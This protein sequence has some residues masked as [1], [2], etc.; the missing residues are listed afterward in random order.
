MRFAAKQ[1][2]CISRVNLKIKNSRNNYMRKANEDVLCLQCH[3]SDGQQWANTWA[4][5][6]DSSVE[7]ERHVI[8]VS[9]I[10]WVGLTIRIGVLNLPSSFFRDSSKVFANYCLVLAPY[11]PSP[12]ERAQEGWSAL[13]CA[14]LSN[15]K[16][17]SINLMLS[18]SDP[19][20]GVRTMPVSRLTMCCGRSAWLRWGASDPLDR[21]PER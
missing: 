4:P 20:S 15:K 2:N 17:L 10:T 19:D 11:C 9:L 18:Q 6:S 3:S 5:L 13:T 16:E 14:A 8:T 1:L 21:C 7:L 12:Y